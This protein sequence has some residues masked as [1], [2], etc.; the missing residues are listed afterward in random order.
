MGDAPEDFIQEQ[1]GKI[2][3]IEIEIDSII[4]KFKVSQNRS[5][6]DAE[7]VAKALEPNHLDMAHSIR[8]YYPN[9]EL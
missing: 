5:A 2:V 8:H 3:A 9:H 1:L 4:G 6:V 7:N